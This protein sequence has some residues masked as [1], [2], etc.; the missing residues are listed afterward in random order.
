MD[1]GL[2]AAEAL[3]VLGARPVRVEPLL[4][5]RHGVTAGVWR[6]RTE[7]GTAIRKVIEPRPEAGPGVDSPTSFRF[8]RREALL[9]DG[10]L[11]D[12]YPA[13]GFRPPRGYVGA[14]V[15]E[16]RLIS[17]RVAVLRNLVDRAAEAERL[18]TL[19]TG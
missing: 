10:G 17:E 9:L 15:S 16:D 3:A 1:D 14:S 18:A 5:S 6:V 8:W 2:M 19:L 13:A 11:P 4:Y 12:A 7:D